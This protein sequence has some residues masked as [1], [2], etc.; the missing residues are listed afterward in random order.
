V[1]ASVSP[2]VN[3]KGITMRQREL[4]LALTLLVGLVPA[5]QAQVS[6]GIGIQAPG[7]SIGINLPAY[8]NLIVVPGTPV[9]YAP[10]VAANFFF[11]DGLYWVYGNDSWYS[12]SWYNGPWTAVHRHVVPVWLLRVPVRYYAAPPPYFRHW[13]ADT[14]PRWGDRWGRDWVRDHPHWDRP[15]RRPPPPPAPLPSYQRG[16]SGP[17]YPADPRAQESI[18]GQQYRY[19]PQ[20]RYA[21]ER[22]ERH[23]RDNRRDRDGRRDDRHDTGRRDQDRGADR[24]RHGDR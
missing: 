18:R 24:D 1:G 6:V 16:Y 2:R 21:R 22:F 9:Y 14:P 4:V 15:D 7:V 12:S 23:E 8:P 11:Y 3:V 19:V 20:D 13:R 5:S 10:G 17:H